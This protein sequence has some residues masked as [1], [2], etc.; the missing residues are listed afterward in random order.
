MR[1]E[2][3]LARLKGPEAGHHLP[4]NEEPPELPPPPQD[5]VG[6]F[7]QAAR[8]TGCTVYAGSLPELR[9]LLRREIGQ[10]PVLRG[11]EEPVARLCEGLASVAVDEP[12]TAA[13]GV[14]LA[15]GAL[16]RTGSMCFVRRREAP[17]TAS[18]V[19][20]RI[21]VL[22]PE[23]RMVW[24][25][26]DYLRTPPEGGSIAVVSG[27]SRSADIENDLSIGVHGPGEVLVLLWHDRDGAVAC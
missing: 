18:L 8:A 6:H 24:D 17:L 14:A 25:L 19:P 10:G 2:E 15:D 16:A 20:P 23:S 27:P 5:L 11:G 7:L 13:W 21:A 1:R 3:F 22:V 12:F 26:G 9:D 4:P